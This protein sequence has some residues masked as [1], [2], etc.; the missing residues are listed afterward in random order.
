MQ[1]REARAEAGR[2]YPRRSINRVLRQCG[3]DGEF[4]VTPDLADALCR[5]VEA[6]TA[7]AIASGCA[8]AKRRAEAARAELPP[9]ASEGL[10]AVMASGAS[11][12]AGGSAAAAGAA[13]GAYLPPHQALPVRPSDMAP[14]YE[15]ALHLHVPGFG[16]DVR[17]YRRPALSALHRDRMGAV[18]H[19]RQ[20]LNQQSQQGVAAVAQQQG[21]QQ[22]QDGGGGGGGG[23]G[24]AGWSGGGGYGGG[25][26]GGGF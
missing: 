17:P 15:R 23:G 24:G 22:Q 4:R 5:I 2:M 10:A 12:G 3:L 25:G 21:Q 11:T 18:L 16:V 14:F 8:V 7:A 13:G 1:R 19:G 26:G 20:Q 9:G 6:T